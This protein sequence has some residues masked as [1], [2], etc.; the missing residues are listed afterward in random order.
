[1]AVGA[2]PMGS[3]GK[4]FIEWNETDSL[5]SLLRATWVDSERLRF[6]FSFFLVA[7]EVLCLSVSSGTNLKPI[8]N[9]S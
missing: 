8:M 5:F 2:R 3:S 6:R 7:L 9:Q 1:M 4:H